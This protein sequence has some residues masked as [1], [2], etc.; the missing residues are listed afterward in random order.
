MP[1]YRTQQ[2]RIAIPGAADL[3]IRSLLDRQQYSDPEGTAERLGISSAAWP[4][5]GQLWPSALQLASRLAARPL[6]PGERVLELGCGLALA[7]LVAHRRGV[8]VTASDKHPLA[9]QFLAHNLSLNALPPMAYRHGD[10]APPAPPG[11]LDG[12]RWTGAV[13]GRYNLLVAS[14]VLY[15]RDSGPMLAGFIARHAMP[16]AE[17]W[18]VD[19]DRGNRPLFRHAMAVQGFTMETEHLQASGDSYKGRLLRFCRA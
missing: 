4:I 8:N 17:V 15:E 14:D 19:P 7:S 6:I 12:A 13:C 10:W 1:G 11:V 18:V 9:A 2:A 5:F 3:L 16:V